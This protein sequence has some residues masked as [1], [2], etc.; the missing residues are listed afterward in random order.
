MSPWIIAF[1]WL[2]VL[3]LINILIGWNSKP[4]KDSKGMWVIVNVLLYFTVGIQV[5]INL[6]PLSMMEEPS[7]KRGMVV[8][9]GLMLHFMVAQFSIAVGQ[10]SKEPWSRLTGW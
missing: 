3:V 2:V 6:F 1:V 8:I 4:S 9:V 7:I 5:F 10:R